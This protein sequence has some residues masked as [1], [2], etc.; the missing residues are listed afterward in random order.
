MN[1]QPDVAVPQRPQAILPRQSPTRNALLAVCENPQ[2]LAF[3]VRHA[4]RLKKILVS[5]VEF[6]W[7]H[8][9]SFAA[10]LSAIAPTALSAFG[11]LGS[12]N[13][14]AETAAIFSA[15]FL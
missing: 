4:R 14:A 11:V 13:D 7:N 1:T 8:H 9:Y 3:L 15:S 6:N 5:F 2:R 10:T 12:L